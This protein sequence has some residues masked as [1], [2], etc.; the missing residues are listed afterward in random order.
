LMALKNGKG[1]G[2]AALD[3]INDAIK[4]SGPRADY[5]DTR[6]IIRLKNGE[7]QLAIDDLEKAVAL[8]PSAPKYFHLAQAY[9]EIKDKEKT[10]ENLEKAK[11]K[12]LTPSGLHPLEHPDY[13][14]LITEMAKP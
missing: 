10:R 9:H 12:G 13:D 6:G 7:T 2:K 3:Y 5:F 4:L 11:N 8:D 14:R 1:A